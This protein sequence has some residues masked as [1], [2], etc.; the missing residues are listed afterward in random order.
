MREKTN[1]QAKRLS[2]ALLALAAVLMLTGL[3]LLIV[4]VVQ[5]ITEV[6]RDEAS[7]EAL[8]E[9]VKTYS[10]EAQAASL[11]EPILTADAMPNRP[12]HADS[13]EQENHEKAEPTGKA[14]I[15]HAALQARNSDYI[16]WLEIPGTP[17]DYP[18]VQTDDAEYGRQAKQAGN[19]AFP[20]QRGL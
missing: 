14:D 13:P 5:Q 19:A 11:P 1:R 17:I 8:R 6:N 4:P 18:V 3:T 16:A 20:G 9:Q 7:Y 10:Q 12:I 15:D 2:N